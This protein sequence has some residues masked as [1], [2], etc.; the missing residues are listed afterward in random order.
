MGARKGT[1]ISRRAAAS[2]GVVTM[3]RHTM[4]SSEAI[5]TRS[6]SGV[7]PSGMQP[8]RSP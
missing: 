2:F 4:I 1:A 8:R 6:G 3:H 7:G 5:A